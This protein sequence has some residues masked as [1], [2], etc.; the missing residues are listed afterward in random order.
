MRRHPL[1]LVL[2]GGTAIAIIGIALFAPALSSLAA[3]KLDT[4]APGWPGPKA[5]YL[6]RYRLTRSSD[7]ALARQGDLTVFQ[8]EVPRQGAAMS[9]ILNLYGTDETNV[10]Y[11][12]RFAHAGTKLW[13]TVNVGVY[14][15]PVVGTF[16][17]TCYCHNMMNAVFKVQDGATVS[18]RFLRYSANPHP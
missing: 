14:S 16:N 2:I 9:G 1:A 15:G 10:F 8:R 12:T 4:P 5:Q 18:L 6:G 17:V 7:N 13:A 3:I 11:V